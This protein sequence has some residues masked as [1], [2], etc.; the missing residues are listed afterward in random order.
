MQKIKNRVLNINKQYKKVIKIQSEKKTYDFLLKNSFQKVFFNHS[1]TKF[2]KEVTDFVNGK[3]LN[4]EEIIKLK[5]DANHLKHF[6]IPLFNNDNKGVINNYLNSTHS[7]FLILDKLSKCQNPSLE[8]KDK[9][10]SLSIYFLSRNITEEYRYRKS[11]RV[12]AKHIIPYLDRAYSLNNEK[13][14]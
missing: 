2:I 5:K 3:T 6:S 1:I 4:S 9:N 10:K 7:E 11:I 8:I 12:L 14:K 13:S